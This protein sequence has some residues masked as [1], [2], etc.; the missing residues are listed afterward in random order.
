MKHIKKRIET[1]ISKT[2]SFVARL[3]LINRKL[4]EYKFDNILIYS[5][6]SINS[7]LFDHCCH[8]KFGDDIV[9]FKEGNKAI[10]HHQMCDKAYA[11][12]KTDHPMLFCSWI[13][14]TIYQYK[15]VVSLPNTRGELAKLL[16][17]MAQ[18]EIY[19]LGVEYG[20]EKHSYVQYCD[21]EFEINNG[22]LEEVKK[23]IQK[24]VKVID[25]FSKKDAYK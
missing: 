4:K 6:F 15:M 8:P 19:I 13:K 7:V 1:N 16:S 20:R 22:S 3:T 14:D 18:Y 23:L 5:N 10:I 25:F 11:K 21:I 12:I 17:Y 9:A 24:K 2:K